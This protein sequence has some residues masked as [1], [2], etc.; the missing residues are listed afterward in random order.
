[1]KSPTSFD[2]ALLC[3]LDLY[4]RIASHHLLFV[5]Y[6]HSIYIKPR[7]PLDAIDLLYILPTAYKKKTSSKADLHVRGKL[8]KVKGKA[9]RLLLL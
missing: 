2:P 3:I 9:W 7:S 4:Y 5:V 8:L 6:S 1:M